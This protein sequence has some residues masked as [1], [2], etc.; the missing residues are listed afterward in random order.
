ME[1]TRSDKYINCVYVQYKVNNICQL[2]VSLLECCLHGPQIGMLKT[3]F[4]SF[5]HVLEVPLKLL[6]VKV[7]RVS[8]LKVHITERLRKWATR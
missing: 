8:H 4:V 2:G 6:V 1:Q 3:V 5:Q 7:T